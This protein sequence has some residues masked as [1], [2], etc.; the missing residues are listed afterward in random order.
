[1]DRRESKG[2]IAAALSSLLGGSAVA[3]TRLVIGAI[4]PLTLAALRYGIGVAC[5]AAIVRLAR[6]RA[7]ATADRWRI[8][9]LGVLFFAV[10]PVLFNIALAYT[11]A[12]RGALAL[13]T[14]PLLTLVVAAIAG[15]EILTARKLAGVALAIGGVAP[16]THRRLR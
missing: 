12:A 5:L 10:F 3:T 9:L 14:L 4:H 16:S 15:A 7:I 11:T 8:A 2:V 6:L 1:M 13:S